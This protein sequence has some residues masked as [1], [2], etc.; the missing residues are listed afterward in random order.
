MG[1]LTFHFPTK[2]SLAEAVEQRSRASTRRVVAD[3]LTATR[4]ALA[5]GVELTL[6]MA[7]LLKEDVSV[8]AAARLA[9]ERPSSTPPWCSEWQ[10][11]L[12]DLFRRAQHECGMR[13]GSDPRAAVAL[14]VQLVAGTE[15]QLRVPPGVP[16]GPAV[17]PVVQLVQIWNLVL[18]GLS[19]KPAPYPLST[20]AQGVE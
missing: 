6:A 13:P 17:D 11:V 8:R 3:V 10:P 20:Q 12:E 7:R 18:R 4:P 14:A 1:A 16:P 15:A 2:Q 9:R 19:V 5:A